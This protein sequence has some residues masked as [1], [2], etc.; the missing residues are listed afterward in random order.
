VLRR[1]AL[2]VDLTIEAET[3]EEQIVEL[4]NPEIVATSGEQTGSEGCL[5]IPGIYGIVSRPETVEIEA[6]DRFGNKFRYSGKGLTAR[7]IC[8]EIDHLN[9][10]LFTSLTDHIL[11][12]EELDK[13]HE[14][15]VARSS[16]ECEE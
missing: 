10:V 7:A 1:A 5:S 2:I 9:G 6:L 8:H 4:I 3:E 11:T 12:E 16:A 15:A 14:E 13:M